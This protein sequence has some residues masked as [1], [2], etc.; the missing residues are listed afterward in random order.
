MDVNELIHI[1]WTFIYILGI[2]STINLQTKKGYT[3]FIPVRLRTVRKEKK[4]TQEDIAK[5]LNTR[6]QTI[7]NYETGYSSPSNEMLKN[8]ANILNVSTDYLLGRTE[9]K[10]RL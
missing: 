5:L 2:M 10:N 9:K 8:I 4:L 6:K 3:P 7:S 1:S